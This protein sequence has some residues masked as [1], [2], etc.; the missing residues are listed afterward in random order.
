MAWEIRGHRCY[1]Y[2]KI[3]VGRCVT[4]EYV[5]TGEFAQLLADY[6]SKAKLRK[7]HQRQALATIKAETME[8]ES[9][10]DQ[11]NGLIHDT[12]F[13]ALLATGHHTH[14]GHWR[15]LRGG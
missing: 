9:A 4:S 5:G 1:F 3:R 12:V 11:I 13:A 7:M 2:C 15:R 8:L 6:G 14:K 10:V